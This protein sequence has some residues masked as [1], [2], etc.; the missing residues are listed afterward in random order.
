MTAVW[1]H[2][3]PG[4]TCDVPEL[5]HHMKYNIS[6]CIIRS[7][8]KYLIS[9]IFATYVLLPTLINNGKGQNQL[10]LLNFNM[11]VPQSVVYMNTTAFFNLSHRWT[12]QQKKK[13]ALTRNDRIK[14]C[15]ATTISNYHQ[16]N[17]FIYCETHSGP[18]KKTPRRAIQNHTP[19]NVA[20]LSSPPSLL[21]KWL[22]RSC[23]IHSLL[24]DN[25]EILIKL[26]N[27]KWKK[28]S[29]DTWSDQNVRFDCNGMIPKA[30]LS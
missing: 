17:V 25:K 30:S 11:R 8:N 9:N 22:C 16:L 13:I 26:M 23:K 12:F 19:S 24:I 7:F 28:K 10:L 6:F 20:N 2:L 3:L 27:S 1:W 21:Q 18:Q 29:T 14:L 4:E 15:L 5:L